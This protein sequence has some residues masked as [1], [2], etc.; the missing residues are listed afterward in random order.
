MNVRIK[1]L[2][3]RALTGPIPGR[4][5]LHWERGCAPTMKLSFSLNKQKAA[6]APA[7]APSLKRPAAFDE[8]ETNDVAASTTTATDNKKVVAQGLKGKV[9]VSGSP[10]SARGLMWRGIL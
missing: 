10:N 1:D 6:A 9:S 2:N 7:P 3:K 5:R 4:T 8:D